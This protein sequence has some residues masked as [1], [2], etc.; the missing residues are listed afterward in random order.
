LRYLHE[1]ANDVHTI[2][3]PDHHYFMS[4]DLE[5]IKNAYEN[6]QVEDKI[7]VTTEK[8][9]A[10]LQLHFDKIKEWNIPIVIVPIKIQYL[11][12]GSAKFDTIVSN[13]VEIALREHLDI[14]I[15]PD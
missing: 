3:Y 9:A 13:Y 12:E 4:R 15:L 11:F 8:D 2:N 7:I 6:W 1:Q 5:E 10:R 14:Q